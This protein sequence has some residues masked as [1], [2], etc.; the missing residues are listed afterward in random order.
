MCVTNF[1][2]RTQY[3]DD[4]FIHKTSHVKIKYN[5]WLNVVPQVKNGRVIL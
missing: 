2:T 5:E 3:K 4:D 1:M